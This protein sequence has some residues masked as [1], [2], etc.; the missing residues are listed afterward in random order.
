MQYPGKSH[1]G[2]LKLTM[3]SIGLLRLASCYPLK[4]QFTLLWHYSWFFGV[5]N[6]NWSGFMQNI[7][8]ECSTQRKD[9][10]SFLHNIDLNPSD[11]NCLYSTLLYICKQASKLRVEVPSVTFWSTFVAKICWHHWRSSSQNR[12]IS[13]E[14]ELFRKHQKFDEKIWYRRLVHWSACRKHCQPYYVRESCL[15]SLVQKQYW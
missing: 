15:K 2:L 1:N 3:Q 7:T 8:Q 10:I 6:S 5:S 14:M 9:Q 12:C 4:V 13:Y 11:E